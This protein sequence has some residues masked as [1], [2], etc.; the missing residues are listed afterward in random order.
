VTQDRKILDSDGTAT[1]T[2]TLRNHCMR[3]VIDTIG[4]SMIR[5]ACDGMT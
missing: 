1:A 4:Q 2:L 5:R 3:F